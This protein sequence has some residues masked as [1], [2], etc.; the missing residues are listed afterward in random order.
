MCHKRPF[1]HHSWRGLSAQV[2]STLARRLKYVPYEP[3]RGMAVQARVDYI[4]CRDLAAETE[5]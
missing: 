2:S 1:V 4:S 5:G 3:S